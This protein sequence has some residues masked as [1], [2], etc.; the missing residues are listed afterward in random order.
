MSSG[1]RYLQV[2]HEAQIALSTAA[3]HCI[4]L[5]CERS[6]LAVLLTLPSSSISALGSL[7]ARRADTA[8]SRHTSKM[9]PSASRTYMSRN[10]FQAWPS[11]SCSCFT[12]SAPLNKTSFT[13][14]YQTSIRAYSC[15][16]NFLLL[17]RKGSDGVKHVDVQIQ[18]PG[19]ALFQL[20]FSSR[21]PPR[22]TSFTWKRYGT[23]RSKR[24]SK[25]AQMEAHRCPETASTQ[26][27]ASA[28]A[29]SSPKP[30]SRGCHPPGS[31]ASRSDLAFYGHQ[32]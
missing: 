4:I 13:W 7:R 5:A 3:R 1:E 27:L 30:R 12:S 8:A 14:H 6:Y 2:S 16:S 29:A 28:A 15:V 17:K 21:A 10:S 9:P 23:Q 11:F 19:P 31:H 32:A 24:N 18:L 20:L 26:A 25:H 22:Q